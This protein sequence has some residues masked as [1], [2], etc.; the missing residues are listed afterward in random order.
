MVLVVKSPP[1]SAGDIKDVMWSQR[2]E[3][4]LREEMAARS[5]VLAWKIPWTEELSQT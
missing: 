4:L 1:A 2:W 3:D 5:S